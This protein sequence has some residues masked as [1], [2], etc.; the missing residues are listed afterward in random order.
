[1]GKEKEPAEKTRISVKQRERRE[2][3]PTATQQIKK[4]T[5]RFG[6]AIS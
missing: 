5:R 3:T 2:D 4:I 1:L 6:D